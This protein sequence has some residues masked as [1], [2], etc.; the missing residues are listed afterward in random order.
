MDNHQ[1]LISLIQQGDENRRWYQFLLQRVTNNNNDDGLQDIILWRDNN[2][3]YKPTIDADAV[4]DDP[5]IIIK[6]KEGYEGMP[7]RLP[8]TRPWR[9]E[10]SITIRHMTT[11][12]YN[13]IR[14]LHN[15]RL[16]IPGFWA[17]TDEE[18]MNL[19][20]DVVV[21]MFNEESREIIDR[22]GYDR[23]GELDEWLDRKKRELTIETILL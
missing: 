19:E 4:D 23:G 22:N 12:F 13:R 20:D 11:D 7:S 5:F 2:N 10:E 14:V 15:E 21:N 6:T 1:Q 8:Y 17:G 3:Q 9:R 16:A 18:I